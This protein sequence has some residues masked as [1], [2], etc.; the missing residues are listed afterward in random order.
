MATD[1]V[2]RVN[3]PRH[4][5]CTLIRASQPRLPF[6]CDVAPPHLAITCLH[7]EILPHFPSPKIPSVHL[8]FQNTI[9]KR[10]LSNFFFF[11]KVDQP[12]NQFDKRPPR[13]P[14]CRIS[15][16]VYTS[17]LYFPTESAFVR[18]RENGSEEKQGERMPR[19][20]AGQ[21]VCWQRDCHLYASKK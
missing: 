14:G 2:A 4:T 16:V 5:T 7:A 8:P 11:F 12:L 9:Y 18:S 13:M 10:L 20:E 21:C 19:R 17:P 3:V 15:R 6:Y 1:G